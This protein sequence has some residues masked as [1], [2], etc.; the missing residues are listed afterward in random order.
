MADKS[1]AVLDG[2]AL[3]ALRVVDLRSALEKRGLP[4]SGSKKELVERLKLQL[5]IEKLHEESLKAE[6][7]VPNLDLQDELTGQNDFVRQYLAAQQQTYS[8]Q[9]KERRQAEMQAFSSVPE[10]V[11]GE[12]ATAAPVVLSPVLDE[13]S[14]HQ[15]SWERPRRGD[16][17]LSGS[18]EIVNSSSNLAVND[19]F[20]LGFAARNRQP[21]APILPEDI[22]KD[23]EIQG[24]EH[25]LSSPSNRATGNDNAIYDCEVTKEESTEMHATTCTEEHGTDFIRADGGDINVAAT[26]STEFSSCSKSHAGT[27]ASDSCGADCFNTAA[28]PTRNV[29]RQCSVSCTNFECQPHEACDL[30]LQNSGKSDASADLQHKTPNCLKDHEPIFDFLAGDGEICSRPC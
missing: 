29:G 14:S 23:L 26:G 17:H 18:E 12:E 21:C 13:K 9:L 19:E 11:G 6:D 15:G 5:K 24:K 2:K 30:F 8:L 10:K 22:P 25:I 3:H 28:S 20:V 7:R 1:E 27:P 16:E 4:K